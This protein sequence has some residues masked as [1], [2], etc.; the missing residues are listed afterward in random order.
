MSAR[1]QALAALLLGVA[2]AFAFQP[3]GLWPLMILAVAML[4]ELLARS[5]SQKQSL[6]IG[7]LFGVGQ[8]TI[9]LNWIATAF[10]FQAAMPAWLGWIAVMLLSLYLAVYPMLAAG[11]A[12]RIGRNNRL[13][14]ILAFGGAWTVAEWLRS[15]VFTGFPWNPAGSS[16]IDTPLANALPF[17][18]TY[19]L[20]L[21]TILLGGLIWLIAKQEW[22][23]AAVLTIPLA[24]AALSPA[25]TLS[26]LGKPRPIRIVQPNIGQDV[27]WDPEFE[28]MA[29]AKLD[30]L[31]TPKGDRQEL[32]FWPE[33][34]VTAPLSDTRPEAMPFVVNERMS[35]TKTLIGDDLL[36]TGGVSLRSDDGQTVDR[37][38]NSVFVLGTDGKFVGRYDKGHLVP[39]GEY[40]PMRPILSAIGLSRLAPG[41]GDF[42]AGSG[43]GT[44]QLPDDWG[45]AGFQ[46]CYEIIF[47]GRVVDRANRPDFV[48]NPSNDAWFG[49]WGP[50]QHLAQARMRAAEEGLPVIRSTPTGISALVDAHGG[51]VDQIPW[52]RSGII[53]SVIPAAAAT[54]TLFARFG[55][56]IPILLGLLF[57]AAAIALGRRPR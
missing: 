48:F 34:A 17:V 12:W 6:L 52:H 4:S 41:D 42:Q 22:K 8:F 18:G 45:K 3:Y 39:Y 36:L 14:L 27:K 5:G 29:L 35:A 55:N 33:A 54:P 23:A 38:A 25:P 44:L 24:L 49:R 31:S 2:S 30:R 43:P 19:G 15:V 10:T 11:L 13:A 46:V 32:V 16:F 21:L 56:A 7:W 37:A 26:P 40:L 51:I 9:S 20:S 47:S 53:W 28:R 57:V 1:I 50:P